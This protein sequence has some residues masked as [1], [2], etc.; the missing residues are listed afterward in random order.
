MQ[1]HQNRMTG[2]L[3]ESEGKR[4]KSTPLPH[5]RLWFV[6]LVCLEPKTFI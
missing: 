3:S 5:T 4:T 6:L 1:F 2:D